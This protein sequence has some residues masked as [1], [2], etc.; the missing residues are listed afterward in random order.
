MSRGEQSRSRYPI[1][2]G[3]CAG[4]SL[5]PVQ[6]WGPGG[7][8]R[9]GCARPLP[10]VPSRLKTGRRE[11]LSGQIYRHFLTFRQAAEA[12]DLLL[13]NR[14]PTIVWVFTLLGPRSLNDLVYPSLDLATGTAVARAEAT[15]SAASS[16]WIYEVGLGRSHCAG[17]AQSRQHRYA[18][19]LGHRCRGQRSSSVRPRGT[20]ADRVD[21]HPEGKKLTKY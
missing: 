18:R 20:P 16:R 11:C 3:P 4:S 9:V 5:Y 15:C 6:S 13:A 8:A 14:R 1:R 19:G 2:H 17:S 21:L 10:L 7:L 12:A